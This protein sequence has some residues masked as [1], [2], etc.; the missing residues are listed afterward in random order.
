M[1]ETERA[2]EENPYH[3]LKEELTYSGA[4]GRGWFKK[5][6]AK[7]REG[8]DHGVR[9]QLPRNLP[10]DLME[11]WRK[12]TWKYYVDQQPE[13]VRQAI[14]ETVDSEVEWSWRGREKEH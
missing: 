2:T 14:M 11:K 10:S 9:P 7:Q 13:E 6:V 5:L 12:R 8:I 4:R 1:V 3:L